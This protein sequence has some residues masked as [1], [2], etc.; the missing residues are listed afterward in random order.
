MGAFLDTSKVAVRD[1]SNTIWVKR[2]MDF[3][4]KCRVEDMLTRMAISTNGN[5]SGEIQF[6]LGAQRLA[7]AVHNIVAWEG[8]EFNGVPCDQSSIERLDPDFPVFRM[9]LDKITD[10]N[11]PREDTAD[12]LPITGPVEPSTTDT[13]QPL[14]T[15]TLSTSV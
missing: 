2:R 7:L 3:G 12:P 6:T 13:N 4:T 10:L 8:P 1:G 11:Q 14:E 9:A 15:A 5:R